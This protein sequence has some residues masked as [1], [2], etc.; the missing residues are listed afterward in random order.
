VKAAVR[1]RYGPP[2][3]VRLAEVDKPTAE[4]HELLVKVH[5]TTVNRTDCGF[6]AGKPFI[7][8]FFSG[9]LRP[10][11]AVLG[12]EFAGVV[13]ELGGGV[14]SF[15]VGDRVFGFNEG[16]FR[17]HAEYLSISEDGPLAIMP[18]NAT[19][20]EA[21]PS[22]EGSHY[23][24]SYIRKAKIRSGQHVLV[25]GATGAI[26]SAAVQLLKSLGAIV[27]A[28]CG[29]EN[30]ELVMSLGA[31]RVID[32]TA[33]DFTTDG[34]RYDV[35]FDAVG[36][37]S[38]GRCRRLLNER[39]IYLSSDLGPLSQNP[40]LAL[41]TPLFRGK[42]VMMPIPPKHDRDGVRHFKE[43]IESGRFKPVIDRRYRLDQIVEAYRY[44]ETGQKIG[45][46]VISVEPASWQPQ[47]GRSGTDI[48]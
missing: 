32:Y 44:V 39:G 33:Q 48:P 40:V 18:A 34:Q 6:R 45:N 8:R 15:E 38:F 4:D 35:V 1:T 27:T 13:E 31:D 43:M 3:V 14:T 12:N 24:L 29:T 23:A 26:G 7:V 37:S 30:V 25:N 11:V 28:V 16:R 2:E 42:R 17:A 47:S 5:V 19:F 46:V 41:I 9:L 22:T 10:R 21:A 20:E 36:K